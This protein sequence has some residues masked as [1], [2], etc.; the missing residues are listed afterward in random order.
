MESSIAKRSPIVLDQ[1]LSIGVI[2]INSVV[3]YHVGLLKNK[4]TFSA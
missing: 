4:S 2:G 1:T 3:F